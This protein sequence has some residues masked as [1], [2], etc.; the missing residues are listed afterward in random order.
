MFLIGRLSVVTDGIGLP[1][2]VEGLEIEEIDVPGQEA[3]DGGLVVRFCVVGACF[4]GAVVG[5]T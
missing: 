4:G 5:S 1:W 2:L 3:A